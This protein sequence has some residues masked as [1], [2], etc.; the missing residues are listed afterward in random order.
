MAGDA[1]RERG[2]LPP[3]LHGILVTRLAAAPELAQTVIGAAAVAGGGS[4][5]ACWPRWP[6]ST[7]RTSS[8]AC[9]APS[10]ASSSSSRPTRAAAM[11]T[12]SGTRC[13]RRPPTRSCC[14]ASAAACTAP[15][16]RPSLGRTRRGVSAAW[17][18]SE[19]AFHWSAARDELRAFEASVRAGEAAERNFAFAD[20]ARHDERALDAWS[21]IEDAERIAGWTGSTLLG[22][23]AQSA[24]LSGDARRAVAWRR[25][26]VASMD[27]ATDPTPGRDPAGAA[28]ALAVE[29][30][31]DPTGAGRVDRGRGGDR[32]P[33]AVGGQGARPGGPR[34][35]AHAARRC[36]ESRDTAWRRSR[37]PARS[38][39]A[40]SKGTPATRWAWIS[41]PRVDAPTALASLDLA[42]AIA[43]EIA[44]TDDIGRAYANRGEAL[45]RCGERSVPWRT[46]KRASAWPS[47]RGCDAPTAVPPSRRRAHRYDLGR[48][49]EA[50]R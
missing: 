41:R 4:S 25:E 15:S 50:R 48:W 29:P 35:A 37:S 36:T 6:G 8:M 32:R 23:A 33:A 18:W 47:P 14:P 28:V 5:T 49:D 45:A 12:R 26:A 1:A 16:P 31:R 9:G 2:P 17:H 24:W 7:R 21:G 20:A 22:R 42:L 40:A 39:R 34:P 19:L 43:N 46:R 27:P 13:S 3:T 44:D 11:S 10:R 38:G 30:G